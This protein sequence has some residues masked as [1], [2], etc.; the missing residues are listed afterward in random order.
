VSLAGLFAASAVLAWAPTDDQA[1]GL[2]D[3]KPISEVEAAADGAGLVHAAIEIPA[4]P[5]TVW[6]V[7]NDCRLIKKLIASATDCKI[8]QG[9]AVNAGWDVRE[10]VTKGN[11]FV[12]T[13]HN[14]YRSDYQPYS[15]IR[16]KKVGGDLRVEEGEWRLEA[17]NGGTATRVI[18]TNL[19]AAN[20]MAPAPLVRE[21]MRKSTAKVL[22]N[23]RRESLSAARSP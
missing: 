23:L 21:A 18:Y 10:T 1:R 13:I 11:L 5:K 7:M 20:V 15:L 8:L 3:G 6:T 4:P 17:L 19:V 12:P 9:D 2:G 22:V 14:I 16:F